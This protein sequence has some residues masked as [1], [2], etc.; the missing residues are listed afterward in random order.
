MFSWELADLIYIY[1]FF[2]F[3]VLALVLVYYNNPSF[4]LQKSILIYKN[5]AIFHDRYAIVHCIFQIQL[6]PLTLKNKT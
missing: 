2:F 4:C 1:I 6:L 5:I 3:M